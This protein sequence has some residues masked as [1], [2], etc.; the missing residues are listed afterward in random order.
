MK[1]KKQL[2][3]AEMGR[4]GGLKSKRKLS[5]QEAKRMVLL[6][7]QKKIEKKQGNIPLVG[8]NGFG[9]QDKL[10]RTSALKINAK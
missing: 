2:T 6:L 7:E 3:A 10:A 1:L 5:S 8:C 9:T 4:L